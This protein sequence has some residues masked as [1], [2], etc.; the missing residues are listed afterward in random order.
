MAVAE[1][2]NFTR[3]AERLHLGQQAVS[4]SIGQLERELGVELLERTTRKVRLTPAGADLLDSSRDVLAATDAAF[5]RVQA[6][7]RGLSG[8]IRVGVTPA[9]GPTTRQEVASVLREG[10]SEVN[11]AFHEVRPGE[12]S[13]ALRDRSFDLVLARTNRDALNVDSAALRPSPVELFV[14]ADHR[15]AGMESVRLADLDGERLLTWSSPGSPYTDMLVNRLSAAGARVEPLVAPTT[16]SGGPP[17]LTESGAVALMPQGWPT[18]FNNARVAV[19]D[20]VTLPLLLLWPAGLPSP[21]VRR[22]REG[23]ES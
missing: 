17:D 11:V 4:K 18:G 3:A 8:T 19:E 1:E 16:G 6:M 10:A 15:F 2:L 20:D 12:V 22:L 13:Q 5:D 23:M 14:P 21:A 9:I 7:D